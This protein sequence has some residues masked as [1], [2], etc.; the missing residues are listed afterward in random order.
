MSITKSKRKQ[1]NGLIRGVKIL[2][3]GLMLAVMGFI[4]LMW[5][6]RPDT[7]VIEKRTLTEFPSIT[8]SSFWDGS[9]FKAVDTWYADTYPL[10]EGLISGSQ[11]L[12]NHYGLR[13]DQIVGEALVADDIPDPDAAGEEVQAAEPEEVLPDGTVTEIGEMQGQIYI[14]NNCGYGLYYFTQSP[15]DKFAATMNQI[16]ANVK[17]KVNL[18]VMICPIS[19]GV[20]LDQ[21]VLDDMGCSSEKDAIDYIYGKMDPGIH[22]VSAFDNL[23]K[24]N[25][26]Y[27]Y[28]H[29]DHHWTALGA[30]YAYQAFCQEKGIEAHNIADYE[31]MEFPGFLG[32]FCSSSNNSPAL[33][34]NPDTVVAYIPKG[35]NA[36]TMHYTNG[37]VVDWFIVNDVS[38]YAKSE[39]Y[40][41]FV[42]GD[43]PFSYAHNPAIT[44][45]SAVMVIKD[46]Y[47]NTFIPWLVD[48]YEYIYWVDARYTSN[49][50]SQMVRDYNVQDVIY[51]VQIYNSSTDNMLGKYAAIGQ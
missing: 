48:H 28:F 32:T 41:T 18:Y 47:G 31:T 11:S 46:S 34:S 36:M 9:F 2:A 40:A 23:K 7:S 44:D 30:Y 1:A 14:T 19:A 45:G 24:H 8:W 21:A 49:T 3:F 50:I 13:S 10:R 6:L 20:M 12:E 15:A 33:Q 35:T 16:Y 37:S 39:L 27:I 17:D 29:T 43:R 22:T 5:F 25:A 51:E 42:G 26:E 38:G 4:G